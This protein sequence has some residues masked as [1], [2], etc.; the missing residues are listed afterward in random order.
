MKFV[1]SKFLGVLKNY[2]QISGPFHKEIPHPLT[3]VEF[4]FHTL[5]HARVQNICSRKHFQQALQGE[6]MQHP[7]SGVKR[8]TVF[9]K[10][11]NKISGN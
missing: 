9:A 10:K 8:P 3:P 5:C 7:P 6:R 2:M 4:L 1:L 11:L